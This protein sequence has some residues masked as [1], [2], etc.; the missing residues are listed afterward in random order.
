MVSDQKSNL[1]HPDPLRISQ[2]CICG[3]SAAISH[4]LYVWLYGLTGI[5]LK[6]AWLKIFMAAY[7]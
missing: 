5:Q 6:A 4:A 1:M 2:F 3:L 7:G